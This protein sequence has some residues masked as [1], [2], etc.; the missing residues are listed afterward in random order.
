M[1]NKSSAF[2][3]HILRQLRLPPKHVVA[4]SGGKDSTALALRLKELNPNVEYTF[5]YTP[6]G[7]E[8]PEMEEH[9]RKLEELLGGITKLSSKTLE[10][11]VDEMG[12]LPNFKR[13]FCTLKLKIEPFFDFMNKCP[14]NSIMYVGLRADEPDRVGSILDKDDKFKLEYPFRS[15]GWGLSEVTEFLHCRGVTIP[16]RTDCGAC[17]FQ[18]IDEWKTLYEKYPDRYQR[19]VAMENRVSKRRGRSCTLRS[20]QRDTWPA[21]LE[22]LRKEFIKG[23]PLRKRKVK[24]PELTA[25]PWCSK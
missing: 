16:E 6:T 2:A 22:E 17:F 20:P 11:L 9:W 25:C 18:R 23:R 24:A 13:R 5:V 19:Y 4:L 10:Q 8:L 12:M 1:T 3:N 21:S 14:P 7:D 15:W